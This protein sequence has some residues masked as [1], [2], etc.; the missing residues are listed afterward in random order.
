M[1]ICS[2]RKALGYSQRELAAHVGVRQQT[3]SR[4]EHDTD[5]PPD[6]R[7]NRLRAVLGVP[8]LPPPEG[9]AAKRV[10][11]PPLP[12]VSVYEEIR[13]RIEQGVYAPGDPLPARS[14]MA[15][16]YNVN[17]ASVGRA[18]HKL[19]QEGW[20]ARRPGESPVAQIP[21]TSL[22]AERV[23]ASKGKSDGEATN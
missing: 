11:L 17:V 7:L 14:S 2:A 22:R 12:A 23:R 20:L 9:P 4:W 13:S 6:L 19:V 21:P 15:L 16:R 10:T 1:Q 8:L 18:V 3:V 5:L